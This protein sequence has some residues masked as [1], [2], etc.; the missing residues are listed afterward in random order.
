MSYINV[1]IDEL[2]KKMKS[3]QKYRLRVLL[4]FAS[5]AAWQQLVPL[6]TLA[7][8][9][10]DGVDAV[11]TETKHRVNG[12]FVLVL[13]NQQ[14]RLKRTFTKFINQQTNKIYANIN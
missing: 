3:E 12:T 10:A 9:T 6:R 8:V 13:N 1:S 4:T 14:K 11:A 5:L 2:L 7:R